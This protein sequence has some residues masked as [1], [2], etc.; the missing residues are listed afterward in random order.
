MES[1]REP[2]PGA[3]DRLWQTFCVEAMLAWPAAP[4]GDL[5]T[6]N[7]HGRQNGFF[8]TPHTVVEMMCLMNFGD[9]DC[10]IK[11]VCDPCLGTGMQGWRKHRFVA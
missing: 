9:E 7:A 1:P 8:P 6:A 10:R 3:S 5:L 4:F 2:D 11:T